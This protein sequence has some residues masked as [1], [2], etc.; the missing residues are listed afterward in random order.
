MMTKAFARRLF[1]E[2]EITTRRYHYRCWYYKGT[3]CVERMPV[4]IKRAKW[5]PLAY[6]RL[7]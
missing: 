3:A 7:D 1:E 6:I 2:G 5:E 4:G